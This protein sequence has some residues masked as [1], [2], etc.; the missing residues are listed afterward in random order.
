M[1]SKRES[2][3]DRLG[4]PRANRVVLSLDGGGI[5]GTMTIQLIK[6]LEEVAGV[7]CHALFDLV[8]GTSTGGIIA[9]L[10][11]MGRSAQHIEAL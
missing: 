2:A 9:G 11:A 6:K 3:L 4:I 1:P 7:P 8:A 10:T 5:R